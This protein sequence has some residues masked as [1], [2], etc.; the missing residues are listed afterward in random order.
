MGASEK[1]SQNMNTND[2]I[3]HTQLISPA[4]VDSKES[5][6]MLVIF[7]NARRPDYFDVASENFSLVRSGSAQNYPE[8]VFANLEF[9]FII[10]LHIATTKLTL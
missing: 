8:T 5:L 3:G 9:L 1:L 2:R 7:H 6:N 4:Q 10:F